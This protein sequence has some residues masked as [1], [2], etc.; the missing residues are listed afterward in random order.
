MTFRELVQPLRGIIPPM[1]TPLAGPDELDEPGLERLI[2][3]MAHDKKVRR[4]RT[5]FV[6][7]R[8]I[9]R[10][11]VAVDVPLDAVRA[12]LDEFIAAGS[13]AGRRARGSP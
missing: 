13:A 12:V 9:G 1:I 3:H 2:E 8:G 6:L 5:A 10:V 11:F 4:G 7:A